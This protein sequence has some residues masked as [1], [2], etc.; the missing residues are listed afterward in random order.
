MT[1]GVYVAGCEP[2]T[3]KSAV[4][5]GVQQLL[6]RRVG[7]L[8]VFRPVVADPEHDPLLDLLRPSGADFLPYEASCGV[9]YEEVRA[10]EARALEEI[11][12][13]YRALAAQCDGVL[14]VGTDFAR[15]GTASELAFNA[16]VAINL[17]LPALL[18]VSGPRPDAAGG[19][20]GDLGRADDVAAVGLRRHRASWPT[21]SAPRIATR[22]RPAARCR[23]TRCPRSTC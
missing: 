9:G 23:S 2:A 5:L 20:D 6:A 10:D 11:V 19:R 7:R 4:A 14:V 8:G 22:S 12:A 16:R 15:G 1:P 18:V 17:G 13:R 21:G 3:G